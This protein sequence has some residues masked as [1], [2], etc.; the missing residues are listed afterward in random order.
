MP[1]RKE[2]DL[3]RRR[4]EQTGQSRELS[5]VQ[6]LRGQDIV[7]CNCNLWRLIRMIRG[8]DLSLR[9]LGSP[10]RNPALE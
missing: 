4:R 6:E 9:V 2:W 10:I 1:L 7:S 5:D 8:G 3:N